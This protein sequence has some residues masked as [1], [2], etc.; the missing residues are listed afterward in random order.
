M[1]IDDWLLSD[2]QPSQEIAVKEE[3]WVADFDADRQVVI[4]QFSVYQRV[5]LRPKRF[6]KRFYHTVYPLPIEEWECVDMVELY[7]GFCKI[8]IALNVTFQASYNYALNNV[9]ILSE[10]NEHI[11]HAYYSL[12]ID[13]IHRELLNLSDGS[14]V[15]EGLK[16]LEKVICTK[17]NEMLV[18]KD[19][20][21]QVKCALMPMFDE[22]P[23][24]K[25]AKESVYLSVLKK[26]F[27]FNDEQKKEL[28][29]QKQKEDAQAI[30][31]KRLSFEQ[32]KQQ[33]ELEREQLALEAENNRLFLEEKAEHQK[34]IYAI[35]RKIHDDK[36]QHNNRLRQ[37]TLVTELERNEAYQT[38]LREKEKQEKTKLLAHD[39]K[40]REQELEAKIEEY[41]KEEVSWR[42]I[43]RKIHD[44]ALEFKREQKQREFDTEVNIKK[45]YEIR[46]LEIQEESYL[47]R[48][49]A[50]TYLKRE[51]ELL[52]L[53]KERLVIKQEIKKYKDKSEERY[54]NVNN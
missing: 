28:F 20:Q 6:T 3:R 47:A 37:M 38:T 40:L 50:D 13:I 51:I 49:N 11:K 5:F 42:E 43:K 27:I 39:A 17:I 7:D 23:D 19:I 32:I 10:I 2:S 8:S 46:R 9:E 35:K 48:K 52:A 54:K 34:G 33:A 4:S 26:S 53:E 21:S 36:I 41:E 12:A 24:V 44:E 18:L 31:H 22:F 16:P 14:W 15:K 25:F 45:R 29:S 1:P 30:E